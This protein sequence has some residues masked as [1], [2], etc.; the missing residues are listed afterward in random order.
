MPGS[1]STCR[2]P[3]RT[4][5]G[6]ARTSPVA[7]QEPRRAARPVGRRRTG[8]AR[9]GRART[10]RPGRGDRKSTRLNSSHVE[11]SY[12]VFCLKKKKKINKHF[13]LTK[14]K[15]KYKK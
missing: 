3:V 1:K 7:R 11:S 9:P 10:P 13:F 4:P 2:H 5:P 12:A 14:K 6:G 15:N 8:R